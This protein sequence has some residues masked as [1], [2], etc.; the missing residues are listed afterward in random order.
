MRGRPKGRDPD[1]GQ[2]GRQGSPQGPGNK[3]QIAFQYKLVLK[4][5]LLSLFHVSRFEDLA[6]YL[7]NEGLEGLDENNVHHFHRELAG[8]LFNL[9]ELPT[10]LRRGS[11]R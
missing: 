4:Q 2:G 3:P 8:P 1:D 7:R 11:P 9:T 6:E 10:E 5:W